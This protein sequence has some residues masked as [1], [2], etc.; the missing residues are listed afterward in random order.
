MAPLNF[1]FLNFFVLSS[2]YNVA[3]VPTIPAEIAYNCLKS[4]PIVK[5]DALQIVTNLAPYFEFQT[6]I[7]FLKDPPSGYLLPGVDILGGLARIE[8]HVRDDVYSSEYDFELDL[9]TLVLSAHDGHFNY[10]P[11]IFSGVFEFRRTQSLASISKDGLDLP[12]IYLQ[13]MS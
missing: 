3:S 13:S 8:S 2:D 7:G 1:L 11:D 4:V 5:E 6:T 9:F 12:K 10:R